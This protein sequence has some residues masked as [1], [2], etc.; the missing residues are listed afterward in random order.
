[1]SSTRAPKCLWDYCAVYVCEICCLTANPHFALQGQTPYEMVMGRMH[2]ISEYVEFGWYELLWYYNQDDF[3]EKRRHLGCWLGIAHR[4]GQACCY[5]I[6]PESGV[7]I[8]R[9]TV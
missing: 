9:S 7:P 6:L 5:Y 1:M 8:V 4:V 3:P 2:D